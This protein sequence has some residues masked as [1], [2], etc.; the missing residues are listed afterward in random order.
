MAGKKETEKTTK[1]VTATSGQ[2]FEDGG[3]A[4]RLDSRLASKLHHRA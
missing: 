2:P 3:A 4:W 1:E